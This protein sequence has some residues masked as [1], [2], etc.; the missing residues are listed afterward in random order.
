[1]KPSG[2]R[3]D[4]QNGQ[5]RLRR[6][7]EVVQRL[8][9][10]EARPGDERPAVGA[11]AAERLGDPGRV[12][13]EELVVLRG[14]QEADDPQL[15]HEV[16]D[17]LLRLRL[18]ERALGEV[19]LEVDVEEGGG[20]AERHGRAVLLLDRGQVGEVQPL[21][22]LPRGAGRAGDVVAVGRRHLLAARPGRGSARPVPP[23][24]E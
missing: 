12:A 6:R 22:R 21:D 15:D 5:V 16:V 24:R 11:H 13:G 18:G 14:A 9:E 1:M 2:S 7:A 10:P 19:A 17:Q 3:G 20:A 23:G 4:H 8:Q